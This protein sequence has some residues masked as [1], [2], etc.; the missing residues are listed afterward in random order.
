MTFDKLT[1]RKSLDFEYKSHWLWVW[2]LEMVQRCGGNTYEQGERRR[3]HESAVPPSSFLVL[4][5]T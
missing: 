4:Q 5:T 2:S 3:V 1:S